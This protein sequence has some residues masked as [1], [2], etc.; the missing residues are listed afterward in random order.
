MTLLT[1]PGRLAT[2]LLFALTLFSVNLP[3]CLAGAE[4]GQEG[5]ITPNWLD[6]VQ[7]VIS[8]EVYN[9]A[10][11]FD[12]FFSDELADDE[13]YPST[14]G[15]IRFS[16]RWNEDKQWSSSAQFHLQVHLPKASNRLKIIITGKD[17]GDLSVVLPG[18]VPQET[19]GTGTNLALRY[20]IVENRKSKVSASLGVS[21]SLDP[22]VRARYR[23]IIPLGA[24][25]L[26][27]LTETVYYRLERGFEET[28][29]VDLEKS[30]D[31][32]TLLRW[33]GSGKWSVAERNIGLDWFSEIVFFHRLTLKGALTYRIRASGISQPDI[34]V[35]TYLAGVNLRRNFYREWLFY[36]I[37]PEI[38]WIRD[39]FGEYAPVGVIT[40]RLE[41]Q[42]RK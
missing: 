33:T 9:Q 16:L 26:T 42:F 4:A 24:T 28:S 25:G 35:K 23:Y 38:Q 20:D 39:D 17:E 36:E 18:D 19:T 11:W 34:M 7:G 5:E 10:V 31:P 27:R 37:E 41:M 29:Q 6:R 32:E 40:A 30:L 14:F 1:S 22:Y 21:S 12:N 13:G 15:R 2:I 3:V 8:R